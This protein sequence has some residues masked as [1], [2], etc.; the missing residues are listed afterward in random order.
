MTTSRHMPTL[1]SMDKRK[2]RSPSP[3]AGGPATKRRRTDVVH[4]SN[5]S[6]IGGGQTP[7]DSD[8]FLS[9]TLSETVPTTFGYNTIHGERKSYEDGFADSHQYAQNELEKALQYIRSINADNLLPS[10]LCDFLSYEV[11]QSRKARLKNAPGLEASSQEIPV[12][13]GY[14]NV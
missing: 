1:A 8:G 12:C 2:D 5:T 4:D 3:D 14:V 11:D 10:S 7:I 13:C 9:D 6:N